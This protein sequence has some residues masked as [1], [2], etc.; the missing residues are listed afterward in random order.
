MTCAACARVIERTLTRLPGV[1]AAAVNYAT[2]RASV[3]FDPSLVQLP[4]IADAVRDVGYQVIATG[5]GETLTSEAD[6]DHA[7]HAVEDREY[8]AL[9]RLFILAVACG[10]PLVG[11]G[12]SHAQFPSVNWVQL[13]LAVPVLFV[14]G[15]RF[16]RGAWSALRHRHADMNTLIALGTGAAFAYSLAVTIAPRL[17][18]LPHTGTTAIGRPAVYYE[19]AATIVILVLLGRLLESRA[20]ARTSDAIRR[21]IRCSRARHASS[22]TGSSSAYLSPAFCQATS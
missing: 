12:M 18:V 9:K 13:A 17:A 7:Q 5:P 19:V 4:G 6:I 20:R 1:D 22:V 21:L 16:H 2:G 10:A 14:A 15:R 11:L 3:R 8:A